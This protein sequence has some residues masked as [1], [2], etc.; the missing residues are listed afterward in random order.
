VGVPGR[1]VEDG[2]KGKEKAHFAA[3]GVEANQ[4]D[5]Y[6]KTLQSLVDHAQELEQTVSALT[7]KMRRLEQ[8]AERAKTDALR[9]VK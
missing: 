4:E 9:A 5:P 2:A 8:A 3:Y 6:A 7:E 1:L